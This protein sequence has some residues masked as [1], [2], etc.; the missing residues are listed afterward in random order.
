[1]SQLLDHRQL[2]DEMGLIV[3]NEQVGAGLPLWLPRGA[4]LRD[5]LEDFMKKL[6][7]KENYQRVMSPHIAKAE[8]YEQSGHLA[9]FAQN[10]FPPMKWP[11]DNVDYYLRPMN[12]PHHHMIFSSKMR[13]YR[14]LP[15]RFSEHGQVYRY[16]NSGSLKGLSR[17]RGLCQN[18]AHIYLK[19]QDIKME[20]Q[21]IIKLHLH[22]YE[23]LGLSGFRFRLSKHSEQ[24]AEAFIGEKDNWLEAEAVLR[25]CLKEMNLDYFEAE[26]EAAFYGPKIDVQ[27]KVGDGNEESIA[28]VQIDFNS[29]R[30][31]KL[32]FINEKGE[33][34]SP[35]IIHRAPLGSYERII[36]ILL[37]HYQGRL[38]FWL[39]PVQVYWIPVNDQVQGEVQS[40]HQAL[41]DRGIRS[42]VCLQE[43]S[44]S[45]KIRSAHL[46]RPAVQIVVGNSEVKDRLV[47]LQFDRGQEKLV[48]LN[49]LIVEL[50]QLK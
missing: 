29:A 5:V 47:K 34:E 45:K 46:I 6:E 19:K 38:P 21:K 33:K 7:F 10:M 39:S 37:E 31:F 43:G 27:M 11:E 2:A 42:E 24:E 20:V 22:C 12:C 48:V 13:S 40:L 9:A 30:R 36:S 41:I 25:E 18:D 1:M 16:E 35:W 32:H 44:L 49:E 3:F 50:E 15:L 4:A 28:S 14:E 23:V 26:G 17:V 8:M